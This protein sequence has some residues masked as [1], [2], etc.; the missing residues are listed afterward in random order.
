MSMASGS[1][2][3]GIFEVYT[4]FFVEQTTNEVIMPINDIQTGCYVVV[5]IPLI[6]QQ[7]GINENTYI[8]KAGEFVVSHGDKRIATGTSAI[9]GRDGKTDYWS[10]NVTYVDNTT[11]DQL[12]LRCGN[13]QVSFA[14]NHDLYLIRVKGD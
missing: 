5:A 3:D 1:F 6:T 10:I 7:D 12:K 11:K 4:H 13:G 14:G 2:I 9:F 8:F